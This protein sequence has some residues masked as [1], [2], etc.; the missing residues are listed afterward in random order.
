MRLSTIT[1][2]ALYFLFSCSD[3]TPPVADF[4]TN[5]VECEVPCDIEFENLSMNHSSSYWDFGDGNS[6]TDDSPL[7]TFTSSGQMTVELTV[8]NDDGNASKVKT[9]SVLEPISIKYRVVNNNLSSLF[10][11]TAG[12]YNHTYPNTTIATGY[13][14]VDS[15]FL[16][17]RENSEVDK[18]NLS[19]LSYRQDDGFISSTPFQLDEFSDLQIFNTDSGIYVPVRNTL[20]PESSAQATFSSTQTYRFLIEAVYDNKT[21]VIDSSYSLMD[22][23]S[24]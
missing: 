4:T 6:S 17:Q 20:I 21:I 9:I 14:D 10:N 18:V 2:T 8:S 19:D 7:H 24:L 23:Y 16:I 13:W 15:Y 11:G 5:E 12:Y 22:L 1:L 3:P